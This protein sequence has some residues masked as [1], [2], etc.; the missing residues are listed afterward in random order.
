MAIRLCLLA[1]LAAPLLAATAW[2]ADDTAWTL[3]ASVQRALAVAPEMRAANASVGMRKGELTQAGSWPNPTISLRADNKMALEAAN[4]SA[5]AATQLAL[6]QPLPL[7]R[8]GRQRRMA[9]ASLAA[10][11]A[12]RSLEALRLENRVAHTFH[13]LQ[14][15]EARYT[16]AQTQLEQAQAYLHPG[17]PRSGLV[18]YLSQA[19][20]LRLDI[21]RAQAQQ[22]VASSEGAYKEAL[23]QFRALLSLPASA[24]PTLS[25][26]VLPPA[27]AP[28]AQLQAALAHSP[29]LRAAR[30]EQDAAQAGIDVARSQRFADPVISLFRERDYF[31]GAQQDITGIGLSIQVPLWNRNNGAVATA[32]AAADHADAQRRAVTRDSEARLRLAHEHLKHLIAQAQDFRTRVLDPAEQLLATTRKTFA[33]GHADLLTLIDANSTYFDARGRYLELLASAEF[34]AADLRLAA[35]ESVLS[36]PG[37]TP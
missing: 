37:A 8:L 7:R 17:T 9:E 12:G 28:L 21:V 27:P 13:T 14:L 1:L 25:A 33:V 23:S 26:L 6:D 22:A 4:G 19:E 15:T 5:Y 16:L 29:A 30:H 31:N 34:E 3:A 36:S 10:A 2:G 20:R 35:G 18:R 11:R 32:R 24:A